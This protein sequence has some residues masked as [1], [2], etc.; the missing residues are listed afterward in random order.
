M[1]E[2][3]IMPKVHIIG[4]KDIN[5]FMSIKIFVLFKKFHKNPS[6]RSAKMWAAI[7]PYSLKQYYAV[8]IKSSTTVISF[9]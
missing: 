1:L 3:I 6:C 4:K 2:S 8:S 9:E 7:L 5:V